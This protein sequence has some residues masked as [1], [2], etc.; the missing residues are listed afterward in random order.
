MS[1]EFNRFVS[2][3]KNAR[4]ININSKDSRGG[5]GRKSRNNRDRP[6]NNR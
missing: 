3:Y 1:E 2:Y 4:D 6:R 5:T